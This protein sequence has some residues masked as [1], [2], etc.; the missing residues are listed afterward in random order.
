MGHLCG[1]GNVG[2]DKILRCGLKMH[3][4]QLKA[5]QLSM[6]QIFARLQMENTS[7]QV[8]TKQCMTEVQKLLRFPVKFF[9]GT[10]TLVYHSLE[11]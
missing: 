6:L 10:K 5:F 11:D 7:K 1:F 8:A 2:V 9:V 4:W 3:V